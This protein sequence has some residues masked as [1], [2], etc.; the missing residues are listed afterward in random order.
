MTPWALAIQLTLKMARAQLSTSIILTTI[1]SANSVKFD[2]SPADLIALKDAGVNDRVVEA[3]M[4]AA[5]RGRESETAFAA[6]RNA[7]EK[8]DLLATSKEPEYILRNFKTMWVDASR[9][10]AINRDL[11][12]AALGDNKIFRTLN[13]TIVDDAAV[14]DVVLEVSYT[15]PWNY[16]FS[17]KHQNTSMVLLSGKG[18]GP[19]SG[20]RGARSVAEELVK[21][22]KPYRVVPSQ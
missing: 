12:K 6:T 1:E 9:G 3:M 5:R 16:P 2:L 22:L 14:A 4:A 7:P 8:S 20:P 17:L 18:S 21:L 10:E 15:F 13:I 11:M 19:F